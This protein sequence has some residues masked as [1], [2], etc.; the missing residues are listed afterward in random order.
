MASPHAVGVVALIV[1]HLG[2]P[3][4]VHGGL[5]MNPN[6]VRDVLFETAVDH[7]CP[8]GGSIHY[9]DPDLPPEYDAT[10]EGTTAF[11]GFYGYGIVNAL[12][13]VTA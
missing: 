3:D 5:R 6:A 11:N 13:A 10:C 9:P 1:S 4:P 8:P 7:A 2:V 12:N